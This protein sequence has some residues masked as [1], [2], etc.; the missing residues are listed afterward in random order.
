V[1]DLVLDASASVDLL[2]DTA[3]GRMLQQLLPS[4][5]RWWVPEHFYVEVAGAL[6]RAELRSEVPNTRVA[7]AMA[8]LP[9]APLRRVQVRPLLADAW[10]KR[11]NLTIADAL[12]VVLAEHLDAALVTTDVR[13]ANSPTLGVA[14]VHP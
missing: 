4:G 8:S 12:Y 14:T 11:A 13:L 3:T 5:A 1:T 9:T 6:R 10:S 7:Q 2:L